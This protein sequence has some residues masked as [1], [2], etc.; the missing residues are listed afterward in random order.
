MSFWATECLLHFD[1]FHTQGTPSTPSLLQAVYLICLAQLADKVGPI[2]IHRDPSSSLCLNIFHLLA[3][4]P[5]MD[6]FSICSSKFFHNFHLSESGFISPWVRVGGFVWRLLEAF[7]ALL[8]Y[9]SCKIVWSYEFM[10]M[11]RYSSNIAKVGIKHQS[12][13]R[14]CAGF[15]LCVFVCLFLFGCWRCM[16]Q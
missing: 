4:K 12:Y 7:T 6:K 5:N 10:F 15:L 1:I 14:F 9:S 3:R 13:E 11:P 8:L 2:S 16:N